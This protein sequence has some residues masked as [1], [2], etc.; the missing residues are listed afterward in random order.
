MLHAS[1]QTFDVTENLEN[2]YKILKTK[3][4]QSVY[5]ILLSPCAFTLFPNMCTFIFVRFDIVRLC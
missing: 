1:V 3:Q 2:F 4:A 5:T